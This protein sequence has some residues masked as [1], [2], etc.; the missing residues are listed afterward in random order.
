LFKVSRAPAIDVLRSQQEELSAV[1]RLQ[2]AEES[3]AL[4][5]SRFPRVDR[6]AGGRRRNGDG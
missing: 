4:Q 2:G 6:P 3:Y 1:N 5:V